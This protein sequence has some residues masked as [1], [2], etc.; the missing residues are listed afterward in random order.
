MDDPRASL[1]LSSRRLDNAIPPPV[2]A[3]ESPPSRRSLLFEDFPQPWT[4][5]IVS[6][7]RTTTLNAT[8][9]GQSCTTRGRA[10]TKS[11]IRSGKSRGSTS[12]K[13][14]DRDDRTGKEKRQPRFA[15][16]ANGIRTTVM[17][18]FSGRRR[19]DDL[20]A[21][22]ISNPP[23]SRP[24][25]DRK[26]PPA[27]QTAS[28]VAASSPS[29]SG[30]SF[31]LRLEGSTSHALKSSRSFGRSPHLPATRLA[32][33]LDAHRADLPG[34]SLPRAHS[35]PQKTDHPDRF[36]G[37][38]QETPPPNP[39]G[40]LQQGRHPASPPCPIPRDR[41]ER[42]ASSLADLA[43][44]GPGSVSSGKFSRAS[45]F[46]GSTLIIIRVPHSSPCHSSSR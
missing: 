35:T 16:F 18:T 4:K 20:T 27:E 26:E 11:A 13:L 19:P 3:P 36:D 17:A 38:C 41:R 12:S 1:R 39:Q 10:G 40:A 23:G 5:A 2:P 8:T 6:S 43:L 45:Y 15:A 14:V 7:S 28:S 29:S 37:V 22:E 34:A 44:D 33:P 31:S 24:I 32:R 9:T 21:S 30:R 46:C 25:V 42:V